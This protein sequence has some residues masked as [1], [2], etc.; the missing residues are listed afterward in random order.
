VFVTVD[1]NLSFQQ[2]LPSFKIA[3]LV[4]S[5]LSNRLADL[6][7]LVPKMLAALPNLQ[8]GAAATISA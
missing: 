7:P 6:Q 1:R 3:V 8:P 2:H 4:L 5:A